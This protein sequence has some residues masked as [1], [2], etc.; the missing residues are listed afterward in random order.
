MS[1]MSAVVSDH[2]A[3]FSPDKKGKV[4]LPGSGFFSTKVKKKNTEF[5]INPEVP[6]PCFK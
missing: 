5:W 1:D 4:N 2:T 3:V 6:H